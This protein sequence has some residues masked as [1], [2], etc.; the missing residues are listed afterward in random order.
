ML[1]E[2][3]ANAAVAARREAAERRRREAVRRPETAFSLVGVDALAIDVGESLYALLAPPNCDALLDRVG[4]VRRALAIE[5]GI[6]I[7]G[8]RLRDDPLRDPATYAIRVRDRVAAEGT[9][10]LDRLLAVAAPEVL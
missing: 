6:V 3:R 9:L 10:R 8:A 7:P 5:I 4:D 1:A 2:L